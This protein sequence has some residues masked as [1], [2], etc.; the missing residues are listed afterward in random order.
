MAI[1]IPN[2]QQ[3]GFDSDYQAIYDMTFRYAREELYGLSERMDNEDW[4]PEV[5]F[6]A[7][8]E[9]GLLGTTIA[10]E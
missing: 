6:R 5:E 9:P 2:L 7:M 3:Y 1:T 4:F 8:H 10:P